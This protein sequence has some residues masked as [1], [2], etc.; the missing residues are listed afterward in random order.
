MKSFFLPFIIL[1]FASCKKDTNGV[2]A[3]VVSARIEAS[4]IGVKIM[5]Q[6]GNAF[7]AMIATDLAHTYLPYQFLY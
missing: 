5:K 1:L 6:G 2:R 3:A 7:D 4:N